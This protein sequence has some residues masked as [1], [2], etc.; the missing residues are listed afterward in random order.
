MGLQKG[1]GFGEVAH[2]FGRVLGEEEGGRL[3]R[4]RRNE[5]RE[6]RRCIRTL[7]L[8]KKGNFSQGKKKG[9]TSPRRR[10]EFGP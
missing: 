6:L 2:F 1:S 5:P 10:G 8:R 4:K 7:L 9:E 3:I